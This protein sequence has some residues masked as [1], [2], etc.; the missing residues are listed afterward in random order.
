MKKFK[1]LLSTILVL[2]LVLGSVM[3]FASG[4]TSNDYENHWAKLTIKKWVSNGWMTGYKDGS[5]RPNGNITR[6]EFVALINRSFEVA[7]SSEIIEFKDLNTKHWAYQ[8]L[9][10]AV[11]AGYI[12]GTGN[13]MISPDKLTTR[14]EAAV[15]VAK[16]AGIPTVENGKI[17]FNDAD[18]VAEWSKDAIISL[19]SAEIL[20]GDTKGNIRPEDQLTRAEAVVLIDN[21][22]QG[23]LSNG[24]GSSNGSNSSTERGASIQNVDFDNADEIILNKSYVNE[25]NVD[26]EG[27]AP[28]HF[29]YLAVLPRDIK[30]RDVTITVTTDIDATVFLQVDKLGIY[31]DMTSYAVVDS[32]STTFQLEPKVEYLINATVTSGNNVNVKNYQFKLTYERTLQEAFALKYTNNYFNNELA[33]RYHLESSIL[34]VGDIVT[35][36]IAPTDSSSGQATVITTKIG[37][38][39][40]NATG[41]NVLMDLHLAR[42]GQSSVIYFIPAKRIGEIKIVVTRGG[43]EIYNGGY[44]YDLTPIKVVNHLEGIILNVLTTEELTAFDLTSEWPVKTAKA[45]TI[46]ISKNNLYEQYAD[47]VSYMTVWTHEERAITFDEIKQTISY[48]NN[49]INPLND[50]GNMQEFYYHIFSEGINSDG[51]F[52]TEATDVVYIVFFNSKGEVLGATPIHITFTEDTIGEEVVLKK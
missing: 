20:K 27:F 12:S 11:K 47:A 34:E 13:Q 17:A 21:T 32:K 18:R 45:Y 30:A 6:S 31:E 52:E 22:L 48:E 7:K 36:T 37:E 26:V 8:N 39:S 10:D 2:Q 15:M 49:R 33:I 16:I 41:S 14:Q 3:V 46:D 4:S 38:T 9:Q 25:Q 43:K 24:G 19:V 28:T 5:F 40:N 1:W 29:S 50:N 51:K 42:M 23:R 44:I 35:A